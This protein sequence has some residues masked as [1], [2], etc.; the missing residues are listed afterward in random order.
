MTRGSTTR[1]CQSSAGKVADGGPDRSRWMPCW[2]AWQL[3]SGGGRREAAHRSTH[4][5]AAVAA[6]NRLE[7]AGESVRA[8][9]E[10][11]AAAHP[12]GWNSGCAW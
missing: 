6:L 8:A 12:G 3:M 1:S 10:A 4:V 5:V 9:L 2:T 7:L 11:L